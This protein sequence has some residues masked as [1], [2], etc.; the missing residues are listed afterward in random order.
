MR[1]SCAGVELVTLLDSGATCGS[2]PEWLFAEIYERTAADVAKGKYTWTD[3]SCPIREI[4]DFSKDPQSMLG[5]KRGT[6]IETK[7]YVIL[8]LVFTPVGR[9]GP[10][11]VAVRLK[12]MPSDSA[13][14]PG[15]VLGLPTVGPKGLQHRVADVGHRF[16]QLGL[17][18]PRLELERETSPIDG[19]EL[20]VES[21]LRAALETEVSLRLQ[22]GD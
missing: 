1:T 18:L 8:R 5:F 16:D 20:R 2:L 10:Q 3:R 4:G 7:F 15:I 14:F 17:T 19:T 6:A 13:G 12:V 22:L 21:S 11:H 9:G